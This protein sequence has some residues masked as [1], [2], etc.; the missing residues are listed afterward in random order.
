M[1]NQFKYFTSISSSSSSS[2]KSIHRGIFNLFSGLSDIASSA[3][4][5]ACWITGFPQKK[6]PPGL[7]VLLSDPEEW[8][9]H[10]VTSN[11]LV[12]QYCEVI[13]IKQSSNFIPPWYSLIYLVL[14]HP[15]VGG[16][17]KKWTWTR[18]SRPRPLI[19]CPL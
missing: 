13:N 8:E 1:S 15:L 10:I 6:A 3:S 14:T 2:D 16:S 5:I 11:S 19:C 18:W 17:S 7:A 12:G 4:F 9:K